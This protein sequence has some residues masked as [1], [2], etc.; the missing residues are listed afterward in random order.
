MLLIYVLSATKRTPEINQIT[1]FCVLFVLLQIPGEDSHATFCWHTTKNMFWSVFTWNKISA[2]SLINLGRETFVL[3]FL[4]SV[5]RIFLLQNISYGQILPRYYLLL[6]ES[7][8]F[9]DTIRKWL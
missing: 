7:N 6:Q 3:E 5:N 4:F 2:M 1:K 9:M 8:V